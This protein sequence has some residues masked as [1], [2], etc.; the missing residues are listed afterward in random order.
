MSKHSK[1][2]IKELKCF[3]WHVSTLFKILH[4]VVSTQAN[5]MCH[6]TYLN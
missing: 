5:H 1:I 6:I 3:L 2:I 4:L